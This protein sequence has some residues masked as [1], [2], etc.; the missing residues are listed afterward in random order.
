MSFFADRTSH[1][2]HRELPFESL[3]VLSNVEGELAPTGAL[4]FCGSGF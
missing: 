2:A 3:R 1:I 4:R